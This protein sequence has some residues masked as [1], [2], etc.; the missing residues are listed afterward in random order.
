[1]SQKRKD[2]HAVAMGRKG[3]KARLTKISPER[4]SEIARHAV[5]TR[6]GKAKPTAA[7]QPGRWFGLVALPVDYVWHGTAH[8][9]KVLDEAIHSHP[10]V[11]LWSQDRAVVVARSQQK[12]LRDRTTIVIDL[13]YDPSRLTI[14]REFKPD[15]GAQLKALK[16]LLD[17]TGEEVKS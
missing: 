15:V 14:Q 10:E 8:A 5:L 6:Y 1:M 11:L 3:G 2:P 7:P 4:R 13:D 9:S 16:S 17:D 12:D